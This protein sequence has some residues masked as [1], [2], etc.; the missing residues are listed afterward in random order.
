[1]RNWKLLILYLSLQNLEFKENCFNNVKISI[2]KNT[3]ALHLKSI[4]ELINRAFPQGISIESYF[5]L[6]T[7]LEPQMSDRNLAETIAYYK[8]ID[9]SEVL[10]DIYAVKSTSIP[11]T[12]AINKVKTRLQACGC[13]EWLN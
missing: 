10:N 2:I 8:K 11:S 9:Y 7:L 1:M 13:E 4:Y 6:L 3:I 5:P 12:E